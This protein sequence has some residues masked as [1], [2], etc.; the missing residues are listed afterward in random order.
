M[1]HYQNPRGD[2]GVKFLD[3]APYIFL[4]ILA[5]V[6]MLIFA[7]RTTGPAQ[8]LPNSKANSPRKNAFALFSFMV[9]GSLLLWQ[10]RVLLS[11]SGKIQVLPTYLIDSNRLLFTLIT[12]AACAYMMLD[13]LLAPT[14]FQLILIAIGGGL[15]TAAF[16]V[17]FELF[18]LEEETFIEMSIAIFVATGVL[19]SLIHWIGVRHFRA[20]NIKWTQTAYIAPNRVFSFATSPKV[21]VVFLL[22]VGIIAYIAWVNPPLF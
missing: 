11:Y 21:T 14:H 20:R 9:G 1:Q 5:I 15:M 3:I 2:F 4:T 18:S 16:S 17:G 12:C 7:V 13:A 22:L 6:Y 19:I 8:S 10:L